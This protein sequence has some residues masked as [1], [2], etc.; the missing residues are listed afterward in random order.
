[1][2]PVT[3]TLVGANLSAT[4]LGSTTRMATAALVV[5]ANLPDLD[6]LAFVDGT[7]AALAMRRGWTHGLLAIVLLPPLLAGLLW[8]WGRRRD[9]AADV[10]PL[11]Y[12]RLAALSYLAVLTHPALDWLNVYG[13]RWLMPFD[14]TW[15]YGDSVFIVDPWL[16][17]L[18]GVGWLIGRR[19]TWPVIAAALAL[20]ALV[21][22]RTLARAPEFA[23]GVGGVLLVLL[24]VLVWRPRRVVA[25]R[26]ATAGLI[27]GG[28]YVGAMIALH[29]TTVARVGDELAEL[30]I[31]PVDELMVAPMPANPLAWDVVFVSGGSLRSA[32]W[33]WRRSDFAPSDFERTWAPSTPL[34]AEILEAG[35][36][37]GFLGWARFPWVERDGEAI[38]LMDARYT[39]ERTTGF[40]GAVIEGDPPER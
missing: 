25:H 3:H 11:S 1:M 9:A 26:A 4:R 33:D 2:D 16:W 28:L 14:G 24:A 38:Y 39:R 35:E 29:Q 10:R 32:T 18:L 31:G 21:L 34:W 6:I 7:D 12:P 27:A 13:M 36:P 20:G 37:A 17:L 40:G 15:F 23:L 5:G 8:W 22:T 30:G 19:P